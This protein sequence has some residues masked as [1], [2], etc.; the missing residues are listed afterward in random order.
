MANTD[1]FGQTKPTFPEDPLAPGQPLRD[2]PGDP[3][4]QTG[5]LKGQIDGTE[6][7]VVAGLAPT[8]TIDLPELADAVLSVKAYVA[9]SGAPAAKELLDLSTD[10]TVSE[11]TLPDPNAQPI[12]D[13]QALATPA[14][15][16]DSFGQSKPTFVDTAD[17]GDPLVTNYKHQTFFNVTRLT[18]VTDQS[19]NNL[20]VTYSALTQKRHGVL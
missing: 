10:Y 20:V 14:S 12:G 3:L 11:V 18:M 7:I 5:H 15:G 16:T 6:Q 17:A 9:A 4:G 19:A 8:G 1:S 13:Q 2:D